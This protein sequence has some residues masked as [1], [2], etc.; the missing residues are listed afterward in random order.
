MP[1]YAYRTVFYYYIGQPGAWETKVSHR[2]KKQQRRKDKGPEDSG[3]PGGTAAPKPYVVTALTKK[4]RGNS[5]Y[6]PW[7]MG[8]KS[9]CFLIKTVLWHILLLNSDARGA[10]KSSTATRA[11]NHGDQLLFPLWS[12]VGL[13]FSPSPQ[14]PL[15]GENNH[16]STVAAGQTPQWRRQ[17]RWEL[18]G[19]PST[20]QHST[21]SHRSTSPG[22][23]RHKVPG[24]DYSSVNSVL[25]AITFPSQFNPCGN[26]AMWHV[27]GV[28]WSPG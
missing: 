16:Q 5:G 26:G 27:H 19:A 17:S 2:E 28:L 14:L 4:N 1:L 23:R 6:W 9:V 8:V 13:I 22:P 3:S 10:G 7:F 18:R 21:A 15:A 25:L 11:G 24:P 12:N 20:Q